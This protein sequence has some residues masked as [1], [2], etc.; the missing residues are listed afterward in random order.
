MERDLKQEGVVDKQ[1]LSSKGQQKTGAKH[2]R[3]E[4]EIKRAMPEI[5]E[6]K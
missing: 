6:G 4:K 5:S 3:S 2:G 1:F